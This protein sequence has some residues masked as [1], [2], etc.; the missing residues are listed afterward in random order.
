MHM[1]I[2]LQNAD[3]SYNLANHLEEMKQFDQAVK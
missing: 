3:H 1:Y 2:G